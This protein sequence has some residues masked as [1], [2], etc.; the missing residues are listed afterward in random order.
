[1]ESWCSSSRAIE[2]ARNRCIC[3]N[4]LDGSW[5]LGKC[6][7]ISVGGKQA[8]PPSI[9]NSVKNE[10]QLQQGETFFQAVMRNGGDSGKR[11]FLWPNSA[12]RRPSG[13]DREAEGEGTS[14]PDP[15]RYPAGGGRHRY[16][17]RGCQ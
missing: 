17:E 3:V 8:L 2:C 10:W 15:R 13:A 14:E 6:Q 4:S 1:M 7:V 11:T 9:R 16:Q 5:L 12:W